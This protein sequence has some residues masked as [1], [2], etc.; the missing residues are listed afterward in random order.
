MEDARDP[1]E[2][3]VAMEGDVV[4]SVRHLE[5]SSTHTTPPTTTTNHHISHQENSVD[6]R[7][8]EAT[9][10]TLSSEAF[11]ANSVPVSAEADVHSSDTS[12]PNASTALGTPASPQLEPQPGNQQPPEQENEDSSSEDDDMSHS[13]Q[14]I[15]ED[16]S[17]P[18][19][20][21][22]R[23]LNEMARR[24]DEHSALDFGHWQEKTFKN[25]QDPD[26]KPGVRIIL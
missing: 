26:Y 15:L 13:W 24:G 14:E 16:L 6:T 22:L 7:L 17:G 2:A 11:Q 21:E 3:P 9:S 19:E 1:A 23:E 8:S 12:S 4:Q 10:L 5:D 20:E 18:S 25:L